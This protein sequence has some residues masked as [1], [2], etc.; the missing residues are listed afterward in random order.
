MLTRFATSKVSRILSLSA[1]LNMTTEAVRVKW[2]HQ[3]MCPLDQQFERRLEKPLYLDCKRNGFPN[4]SFSEV[5]S[6]GPAGQLV[7]MAQSFS[8]FLAPAICAGS[9]YREVNPHFRGG[10]VENH[11]GKTTPSSPTEILA[12]ISPS[13]AVELNTTNALANYATEADSIFVVCSKGEY[14]SPRLPG[15][16]IGTTKVGPTGSVVLF[17]NVLLQLMIAISNR[18]AIK[19]GEMSSNGTISNSGTASLSTGWSCLVCLTYSINVIHPYKNGIMSPVTRTELAF[20]DHQTTSDSLHWDVTST[21]IS[22]VFVAR[23]SK[24]RQWRQRHT[25]GAKKSIVGY[26]TELLSVQ[27]YYFAHSK[28]ENFDCGKSRK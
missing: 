21:T 18:A 23:T 5:T 15:M 14:N 11:L 13:S 28:S 8:W 17:W 24:D 25:L 7:G 9:A 12:L 3:E 20:R 1:L 2:A 22:T 27:I 10:R 16:G 6:L 4:I 26:S 19:V